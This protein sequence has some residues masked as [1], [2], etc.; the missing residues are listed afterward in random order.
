[1]KDQSSVSRVDNSEIVVESFRCSRRAVVVIDLPQIDGVTG[2]FGNSEEEVAS[3]KEE[4][5]SLSI[6]S[7]LVF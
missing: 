2:L 4:L 7:N 3:V 6:S 1:M 5:G